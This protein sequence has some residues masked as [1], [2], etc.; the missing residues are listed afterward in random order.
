MTLAAD[1]EDV[2]M[3]PRLLSLAVREVGAF[4]ENLEPIEREGQASAHLPQRS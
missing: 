1:H 2:L 4:L 3:L